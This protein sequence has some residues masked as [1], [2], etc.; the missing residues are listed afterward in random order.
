V[1]RLLIPLGIVA[2]IALAF[3]G[4]ADA[5]GAFEISLTEWKI[6]PQETTLR[7]GKVKLVSR[8]DGKIEHELLVLKTDRAAESLPLGLDGPALTLPGMKLVVGTPHK[9]GDLFE[10]GALKRKHI[11]AG[12]S[13]RDSITLAK[14]RY[15]LLC[16]L[17]GHY[18]A[19]QR[20][21]LVVE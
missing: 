1:R 9:H 10:P 12:S 17:P 3:G 19:G 2:A 15:V 18:Q 7:A 6:T 13:R 11:P 16:N 5:G 20:A 8:N 14:G 4:G 21:T